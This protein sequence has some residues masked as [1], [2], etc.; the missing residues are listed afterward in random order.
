ML[1]LTPADIT[2]DLYIDVNKNY[3]VV[4]GEEIFLIPKTD[5]GNRKVSIPESLYNEI[6]E[7]INSMYQI[8]RDERIFYFGKSGVEHEFHRIRKEAGLP[9]IRVHDLRHSHVS[10]L[11]R[12]GVQPKEIA[13]KLH[14]LR[15][16]DTY[17]DNR[18]NNK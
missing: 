14:D 15:A 9:R 13:R 18:E 12:I 16:N 1:A 17:P 10:L 4:E 8:G 2:Q 7:Y 11:I 5:K 3:Q 6:Q